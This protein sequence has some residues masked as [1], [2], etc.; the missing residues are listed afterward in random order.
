V[1]QQP[2]GAALFVD[3]DAQAP[4]IGHEVNL[5]TIRLP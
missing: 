2:P 3:V 4:V 1:L 5:V